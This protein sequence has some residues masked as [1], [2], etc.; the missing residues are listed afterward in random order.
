MIRQGWQVPKHTG[1]DFR[2]QLDVECGA[3][4]V[5]S[6]LGLNGTMDVF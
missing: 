4:G 2:H 6:E 5:S 1:V 3:V